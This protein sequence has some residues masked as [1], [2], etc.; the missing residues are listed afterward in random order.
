DL[1]QI[2]KV[3]ISGDT[4][5][6]E[7]KKDLDRNPVP[8]YYPFIIPSGYVAKAM[9]IDG[10][11]STHRDEEFWSKVIISN[12][13]ANVNIE[14]SGEDNNGNV[15]NWWTADQK[16]PYDDLNNLEGENTLDVLNFHTTTYNIQVH[17]ICEVHP[18]TILSWQLEVYNRIMAKYENE[19]AEYENAKAEYELRRQNKFN[20]NPFILSNMMKKQLKQAAIN[21]ISCQFFDENNVIKNRVEPCGFPQMD[22]KE[23]KREGEFVR[24][25]EQ[26]FEWQFMNYML[27]PYFY[28]RKCSWADKLKEEAS[29][30]LFA[31]FLESGAARISIP[32]CPNFEGYVTTYLINRQISPYSIP[33]IPQNLVPIHEEIKEMKQNFNTDRDGHIIHDTNTP[34]LSLGPNE[35]VL[36]NNL[37]YFTS[38][39]FDQTEA[40]KDKDREIF[41]NCNRYRILSIRL[42]STT[43]EIIL[44]LGRPFEEEQNKQWEWSTGAV[45]VGSAWMFKV[46]TKLVW[47]REEEGCLPCY[48]IECDDYNNSSNS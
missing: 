16:K 4:P 37:D 5:R 39:V 45:F 7:R 42:D 20:Q 43:N 11:S 47:L 36:R 10:F 18:D 31:E 19:L 6:M 40:D 29:N 32:V 33:L 38:S 30:G 23:A 44:T 27:Y 17:I 35:I 1:P 24:F 46:P 25:F 9:K 48:P 26:A 41:I 14:H 15:V 12:G 2:V 21:Y 22:L 13:S 8:S 34:G 28:A 3:N